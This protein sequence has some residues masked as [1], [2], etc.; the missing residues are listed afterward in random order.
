M[1]KAASLAGTRPSAA[2]VRST[3]SAGL[4]VLGVLAALGA[5]LVHREPVRVIA[6]VLLGDVVAVL[7]LGARHGDLGPDVG[8]LA[9]H[10]VTCSRSW[11]SSVD[12]TSPRVKLWA[13]AMGE[14]TLKGTGYAH[15]SPNL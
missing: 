14:A 3:R 2:A 1:T 11:W 7:A 6:T 8:R 15:A 12:R 5:E 10:G 13:L 4:A 9:G